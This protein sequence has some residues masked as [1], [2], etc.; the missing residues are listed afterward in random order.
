M[1]KGWIEKTIGELGCFSKGGG[2][3]R[4]EAI[5]GNIPAI[6]Y[7]EIYT[8]HND[9]IKNYYSHIST[10]VANKATQLRYGD[11]LFAASGETKEEIGKC[12]AFVD[13]FLAYAGGDIIILS[14]YADNDPM[15]LGY[16]F[17]SPAVVKQKAQRGQGDAIVHITSK[18]LSD[19]KIS[20]PPLSEQQAIAAA[21]SDAD[22]YIY[23]LERLISKKRDIKQGA[24]QKLLTG[25]KRL[26]GFTSE[27]LEKKLG[28]VALDIRTGKRNNEEKIENGRYPFFIRSQ[29]VEYINDYSYDCEAILVPGEGNIGQIFHY[30]N[31]KFD[32]HQRVYKIS[33]FDSVDAIFI[34][35]YLKMFFGQ[36]ALMNTVKA[37]VDSLRLPTFENFTMLIPKEKSEQTAIATILSDMDAEIDVLTAQL[38]KA[39]LIKQGMMQ[40]LLTGRIRLIDSEISEEI[41]PQPKVIS[42]SKKHSEQF[43]DAVAFAVIVE[44]FYHFKYI[45][46]RVKMNKLLYLLRRHQEVEVSSFAKMPAGPYKS[47][48]RYKGG[49]KIAINS[50]YIIETKS[51]EGSSFSKGKDISNA[52]KYAEE[53]QW[54]D[55]IT[56]LVSK[57]QYK[58][59]DDLETLATV[60][61][62]ACE[63]REAGKNVNLDSVKGIIRSN[64]EWKPK[65]SKA[66]FSD[67]NIIQ[68]IKW[69]IE[70][71]GQEV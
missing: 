44:N 25:K 4:A 2:I 70:L 18:T 60:D 71:F 17:N 67:N 14:I 3:S 8:K 19:I 32:C 22:C 15:F 39:K 56:W 64:K 31:G 68:A 7:G 27:W 53:W 50:G 11:L 13:D 40:K 16:L 38:E 6:R 23:S 20:L 46:G 10:D 59:R 42:A 66:H 43:D 37:T 24:M 21:L 29:Q 34:F 45:L 33:A 63:L 28:D 52:L 47:E 49:E 54:Q 55:S 62:A 26:S 65:L 1:V 48:T 35:Y 51:K 30:I 69:S 58:T 9:Y 12:I 36:Y 5:S 61:M 57:F 41:V